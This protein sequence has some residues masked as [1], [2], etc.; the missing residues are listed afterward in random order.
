MS[1]ISLITNEAQGSM[2]SRHI[3]IR[4]FFIRDRVKSGEINVEYCPTRLMIADLLT[5]PLEGILFQELKMKI[6]ERIR[7]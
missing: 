1:T 3:G 7:G 5:K 6:L 4:Y 2:R